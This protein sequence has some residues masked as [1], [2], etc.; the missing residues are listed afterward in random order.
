MI[1]L[2]ATISG[3]VQLVM[4]RDFV[5]RKATA[6]GLSGSVRNV[7][8]GTVEV[9]A[10]GEKSALEKLVTHLH[11]G[12]LLARVDGVAVE[13]KEPEGKFKGFSIQY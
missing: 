10:E 2:K 1:G 7:E 6:L 13:W 9:F 5:Q 11:K 4:F 3:R 8:D 12:P